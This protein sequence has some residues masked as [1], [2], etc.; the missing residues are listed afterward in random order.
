M[1]LTPNPR[2]DLTDARDV[3]TIIQENCVQCHRPGS[4]APMPLETCEQVR[5]PSPR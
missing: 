2:T 3:A 4:V 1:T 5:G